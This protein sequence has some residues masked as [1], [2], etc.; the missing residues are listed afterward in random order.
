MRAIEHLDWTN[1][2][3]SN[4]LHIPI[5]DDKNVI[6]D[7][8]NKRDSR[9]DD[10]MAKSDFVLIPVCANEDFEFLVSEYNK[11]SKINTQSEYTKSFL[12]KKI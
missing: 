10:V 6:F 8:N 3:E 4:L 5:P 11:I 7:L 1:F 9:Y 2:V 12:F